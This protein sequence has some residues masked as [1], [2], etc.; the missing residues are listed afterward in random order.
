[1]S[2]FFFACG[3]YHK[4]KSEVKGATHFFCQAKK[5]KAL[6]FFFFVTPQ[7]QPKKKKKNV[8]VLYV[9]KFYIIR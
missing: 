6:D 4:K 9:W 1:M 2:F 5:T 3:V 8:C 7:R